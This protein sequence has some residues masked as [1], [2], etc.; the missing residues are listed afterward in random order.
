MKKE[1]RKKFVGQIM[2]QCLVDQ[3]TDFILNHYKT[4]WNETFQKLFLAK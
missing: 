3:R 4:H 2:D 1:E